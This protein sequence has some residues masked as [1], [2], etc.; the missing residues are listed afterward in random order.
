MSGRAPREKGDRFERAIV[1]LLQDAGIAG[2]RI[3]CSGSCGGSFSGDI[4]VPLLGIDRV[5]ECKARAKG[6]APLYDWLK[7]RD[8]LIVKRTRSDPLVIV[9]LRVAPEIAVAAARRR[10]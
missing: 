10:P 9:P 2:E 4:N 1:R 7:S 6:F 8:I 3:P 5:A